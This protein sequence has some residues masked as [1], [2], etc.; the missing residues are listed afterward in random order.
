MT[1]KAKPILENR[2]W[3]I[4][5]EGVRVG[6]LSKD[7]DGFVFSKRGEVSFFRDEQQLKKTFG[8]NFLIAQIIQSPTNPVDQTVHGYPTRCDPFNSMFDIQRNLPLFTK[9]EKSKSVY[10]AG[11][12]LVKFNI[13]WLKSFCPKLITLERNEYLGPFKTEFEMKAKLAH[14]NRTT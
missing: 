3:V 7:A 9:S 13:S 11:Y 12:Y 6:T 1:I 14:V 4:E 2:F 10:C 8:K 5:D